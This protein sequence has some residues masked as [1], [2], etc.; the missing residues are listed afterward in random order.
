MNA[1]DF[2]ALMNNLQVLQDVRGIIRRT[3]SHNSARFRGEYREAFFLNCLVIY[4]G[5]CHGYK[6]VSGTGTDTAHPV[7]L[8]WIPLSCLHLDCFKWFVLNW[9]MSW[10]FSVASGTTVKFS[11]WPFGWPSGVRWE[12]LGLLMCSVMTLFMGKNLRVPQGL[13]HVLPLEMILMLWKTSGGCGGGRGVSLHCGGG[14]HSLFLW[15]VRWLLSVLLMVLQVLLL[16]L[17]CSCVWEVQQCV[18]CSSLP[19]MCWFFFHIF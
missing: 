1:V 13:V 12:G 3:K 8:T 15:F 18:W 6:L 17:Y 4:R 11:T 7:F 9:R 2:S 14:H 10:K 5:W 16:L 19:K